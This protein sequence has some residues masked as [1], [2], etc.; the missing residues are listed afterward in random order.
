MKKKTGK[1]SKF[2]TVVW[3]VFLIL[4]VIT[5]LKDMRAEK[6]VGRETFTNAADLVV[7]EEKVGAS[8][9]L[10]EAIH[11]TDGIVYRYILKSTCPNRD[12]EDRYVTK[13]PISWA[14]DDTA[15][16]EVLIYDVQIRYKGTVYASG[17]YYKVPLFGDLSSEDIALEEWENGLIEQAYTVYVADMDKPDVFR[18]IWGVGALGIPF[19]LILQARVQPKKKKEEKEDPTDFL[20]R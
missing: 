10:K 3:I 16:V 9:I 8:V 5:S 17:T 20:D 13:T 7:N 4:F 6:A 14:T 1:V 18:T 15:A 19:L 11:G 2:I 12:Y